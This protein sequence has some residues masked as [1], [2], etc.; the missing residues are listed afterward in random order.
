MNRTHFNTKLI[1]KTVTHVKYVYLVTNNPRWNSIF[2]MIIGGHRLMY[3]C[4]QMDHTMSCY[5][6]LI[7]IMTKF[8]NHIGN[9]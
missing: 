9:V 2:R 8:E 5:R 6:R 7:K 4:G 1:Q 3:D